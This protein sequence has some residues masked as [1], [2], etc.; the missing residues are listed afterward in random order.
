MAENFDPYHRWLGI[1]PKDQPPTH[2]RLLGLAEF[3]DDPDVI[4]ESADR[5]MGHIRTHQSG[6]YAEHS[7]RLLSEITD[8]KFC[9]LKSTIKETYD[10]NLRAGQSEQ[11]VAKQTAPTAAPTLA[12]EPLTAPA[13]TQSVAA[14]PEFASAP[15]TTGPIIDSSPRPASSHVTTR[16]RQPANWQIP[17]IVA[18]AVVGVVFIGVIL[19]FLVSAPASVAEQKRKD[20]LAA[21]AQE[22]A[23]AERHRRLQDRSEADANDRTPLKPQPAP[24]PG[25]QPGNFSE[26]GT[27]RE[28]G[29]ANIPGNPVVDGPAE[30]DDLTLADRVHQGIV[31][32]NFGLDSRVTGFVIDRR[33]YIVVSYRAIQ[34]MT[35]GEAFFVRG[36]RAQIRGFIAAD[37]TR[38]IAVLSIDPTNLD[39]KPLRWAT[40][41][42][43]PGH[44]LSGFWSTRNGTLSTNNSHFID[45]L[46]ADEARASM[47]A[48][49]DK[50]IYDAYGFADDAKWLLVD[51]PIKKSALGCPLVTPDAEVIGMAA[52]SNEDVPPVILAIESTEIQKVIANASPA[53]KPLAGLWDE[54]A[55]SG[56]VVIVDELDP[57]SPNKPPIVPPVLAPA[58]ATEADV[59]FQPSVGGT[60]RQAMIDRLHRGLVSVNLA[61]GKIVNGFVVD[62]RGYVA[63]CYSSIRGEPSAQAVFLG[64][65]RSRVLGVVAADPAVDIAILAIERAGPDLPVLKIARTPPPAGD[66]A[67]VMGIHDNRELGVR[68]N[69]FVGA[70]RGSDVRAFLRKVTAEDVFA[71]RRYN[72]KA[73]WLLTITEVLG[74]AIGGPMLNRKG[75][76]IGLCL[77]RSTAHPRANMAVSANEIMRLLNESQGKVTSL[78]ELD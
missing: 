23:A 9:L 2:Y 44:P 56:N 12:P 78:S 24:A 64:G 75:D 19:Y 73:T 1:P 60:A 20:A 69:G 66:T 21:Q 65:A 77:Y 33:G 3:E 68:S 35:N 32:I 14:K 4:E 59:T 46:T 30:Q 67:V 36:P 57:P 51:V 15:A 40:K 38:D 45:K 74:S 55:L 27:V 41:T 17:V 37:K 28:D 63:T 31:C 42:P 22:R 49:T 50:D 58:A 53:V 29:T 72:E 16:H 47:L 18:M 52:W 76:V 5:Q 10:A 25:D 54:D 61:S 8:A 39:L 71:K 26:P 34:D 43:E 6:Q 11:Q 7:Q 62:Q 48:A 70:F 13:P